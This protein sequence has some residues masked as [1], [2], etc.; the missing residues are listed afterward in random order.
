[1]LKPDTLAFT[2]FLAILVSFG[3][4]STDM[5]LPSLPMI[6][7]ELS[8]DEASVQLTLSLFL[9]GFA[10]GQI[11]YGP[12]SDRLGRRPLLIAGLLLY[13]FAS[14]ACALSPTI[15]VLIAARFLQAFGAAGPIVIARSMVRDVYEGSRAGKELALIGSL[16]GLVPAVAPTIGG[17]LQAFFGWPSS[18]VGT[19]VFG[20]LALVIVVLA[21]GETLRTRQSEPLTVK[22]VVGGFGG[23]LGDPGYRAYVTI[24]CATFGGLFCF[25]S[26]SPFI[27]QKIYGLSEI[28]YGVA[29]GLCALSYATGA[30]ISQRIVSRHGI[31]A[32]VR[33][34][35]IIVALAGALM[36]AGVAVGPGHA[37]E[38]VVPMMVYMAG[39]GVGM[40][41]AM[42]GALMPFPER[43]G[44]ASSLM[45][46]LQMGSG[47]VVGVIFG[48]VIGDTAWPLAIAIALMGFVTLAAFWATRKA[49]QAKSFIA[50]RHD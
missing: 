44:A 23:L 43:A 14:L 18:F 33:A 30:F 22:S 35:A 1:M 6:G 40:P 38:I 19:A 45:G 2:L 50:P 34:G 42:A 20:T 36:L 16:M 37:A 12:L 10:L 31:A 15:E 9:V 28:A 46:F 39:V 8:A 25:I 3:P 47:A 11:V 4:V 24:V 48:H 21:L 7:T 5:Y 32:L 41:Q 17:V 27:L 26:G 49:R 13:A 29:F